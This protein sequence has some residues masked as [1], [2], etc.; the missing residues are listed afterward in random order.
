MPK[1]FYKTLF[2]HTLVILILVIPLFSFAQN[3][4][5]IV[6]EGPDNCTFDKL[7]ELGVNFINFLIYL[8]IPLSAISFVWAGAIL[9]TSGG[10]ESARDKAKTIMTKTGI[11]LIIVLAAWLI[12]KT[13]LLA[14]LQDPDYSLLTF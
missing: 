9:L 11:G 10:K 13:V 4:N 6:C 12:V 7:I 1:N 14:L 5:L 3:T 8:A 2:I